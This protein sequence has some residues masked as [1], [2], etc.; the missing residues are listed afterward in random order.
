MRQRYCGRVE[1][2]ESRRAKRRQGTR[3]RGKKGNWKREM[4]EGDGIDGGRKKKGERQ[5]EKAYRIHA[6]VKVQKTALFTV[7]L[8]RALEVEKRAKSAPLPARHEP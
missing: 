5:R 2:R 3:K 6:L 8:C 1:G 7:A 4:E